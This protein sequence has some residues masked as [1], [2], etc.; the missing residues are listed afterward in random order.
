MRFSDEFSKDD[1]RRGCGHRAAAVLAA[2]GDDKPGSAFRLL[3]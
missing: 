1:V 2:A 3:H